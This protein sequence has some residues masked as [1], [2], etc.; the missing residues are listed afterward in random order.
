MHHVATAAAAATA[1]R[2][3]TYQ[4]KHILRRILQNYLQSHGNV[5]HGCCIH[6]HAQEPAACFKV[7]GKH[8][9]NWYT[10]FIKQLSIQTAAIAS[11][12][13]PNKLGFYAVNYQ[14]RMVTMTRKLSDMQSYY[15]SNTSQH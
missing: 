2:S 7:Y 8:M 15:K 10:P 5:Y 3:Q 1:A 4:H 14:L 12:C 11:P 6:L 13:T 9:Q